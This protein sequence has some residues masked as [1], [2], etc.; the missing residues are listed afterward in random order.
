MKTKL[1]LLAMTQA[2]YSGILWR[3]GSDPV[4]LDQLLPEESG[5]INYKN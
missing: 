3:L 5:W 2:Y 4:A 1:A